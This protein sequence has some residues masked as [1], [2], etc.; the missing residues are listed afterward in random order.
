MAGLKSYL[1]PGRASKRK[2]QQPSIEM[3]SSPSPSSSATPRSPPFPPSHDLWAN[4]SSVYTS[5]H[6]SRRGSGHNSPH[7]VGDF[8][9]GTMKEITDIKCEVMVQWLHARQ[10]E[11]LWTTGEE[12]EGVVLK[13]RQGEYSCAPAELR[14]GT[15]AE[16]MGFLEAVAALNVRVSW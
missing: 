7:P 14:Y 1:S 2:S 4:F 8:R 3:S 9:N 15:S 6:D 10:E 13:K 11:Q 16:G 5:P 12:D